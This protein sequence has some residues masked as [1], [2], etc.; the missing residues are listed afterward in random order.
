[1]KSLKDKSY[2]GKN[3]WGADTKMYFHQD[4]KEAVKEYDDFR[5][6]YISSMNKCES[7]K[8]NWSIMYVRKRYKSG[9]YMYCDGC[10]R[11]KIFGNFEEV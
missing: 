6:T 9:D 8:K 1:M 4:V 10:L 3:K 5:L 11:K 2:I 7:C